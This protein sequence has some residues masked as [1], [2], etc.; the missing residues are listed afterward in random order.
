MGIL[1]PLEIQAEHGLYAL[2]HR[3]FKL[4]RKNRAV[5]YLI[6]LGLYGL[7]NNELVQGNP[8]LLDG[9]K[10]HEILGV[11]SNLLP[12]LKEANPSAR[13]FLVIRELHKAGVK[14]TTQDMR[15]IDSA[16]IGRANE[17]QLY[18]M[19]E[20]SSIHKALKYIKRQMRVSGSDGSHVCQEWSD[21][22]AMADALG[23]N[24]G[25][26]CA[27]F[28]KNLKA[29]HMEAAKLQEDRANKKLNQKM[30]ITAGKLQDLCWEFNGL[31]IR[32]ATDQ[33]ELFEEGKNLS[34]C[35][36]RM[37]Y[38]Q[39]MANG[40]TAIFFIRKQKTPDVSFVTLELDLSRWEKIQCYG[41]HDTHPGKK[42][43]D[44]V[45]RWI[46]EIVKPSRTGTAERVKIAV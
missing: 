14:L 17:T 20:S 10:A 31:I 2:P 18:S 27:L 7:A 1:A 28:P 32:P 9:K 40:T 4:S 34:H 8:V 41:T 30:A 46:S 39:K 12:A 6:K 19:A 35:V 38:A 44:F 15:D 5:E 23:M 36:G 21:Y 37:G 3:L 26:H 29:A 16:K 25:D 24:L 42:V 33:G 13:A 22:C 45:A 43:D 11:D